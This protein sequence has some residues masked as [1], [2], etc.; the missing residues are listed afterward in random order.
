M[1]FANAHYFWFL[2]MLFIFCV[3]LVVLSF[4]IKK[5]FLK[6][7]GRKNNFSINNINP[8]LYNIRI[9]IFILGL[10]FIFISLLDPR[11]GSKSIAGNLEGID[12]VLTFDISR[13]MLTK[14][15]FPDRLSE[16]KRIGNKIL[17]KLIGNR[18]GLTAF[19]GFA[20]NIIPLTT[21]L[22]AARTFIDELNT[23]MIDIQGTNLEDA[24]RKAIELF[25]ENI[26][27]H[28]VIVIIT[29]GE[30]YEFNPMKSVKI[31][32]EKGIIIFTV[33]IGT[34]E[35][36]KIPIFDNK[37]NIIDYLKKDGKVV[38]SKLNEKMLREIAEETKGMYFHAKD[39]EKLISRIDEIKKTKYG[40]SKYEFLELQYQYFLFIALLLFLIY[41]FLPFNKINIDFIKRVLI[42][43]TTLMLTTNNAF[44]SL[45]TKGV[46]EYKKENYEEALNL[47]QKA[48]IKDNKNS[49]L[50]YNIGNTYYKLNNLENAEKYY[51][52][53]LNSTDKKLINKANYNL[54]NLYLEKGNLIEAIEKYK[55]VLLNEKE[56]SELYKK[57]LL[58]LLYAK[59]QINN[60]NSN[61]QNQQSSENEKSKKEKQKNSSSSQSS[62]SSSE[63]QKEDNQMQ[64]NIDAENLLNLLKEEEKKHM[65]KKEKRKTIGIYPK[66]EW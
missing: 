43:L 65:S 51:K 41:I 10:F 12:I 27:T 25:D 32:K 58:N 8:F 18:V 63:N 22:E 55:E 57:A 33:G 24:I 66:N 35:G 17:T 61:Q 36:E 62:S 59:Q 60:T 42:I 46:K 1:I 3:L 48:L 23:E 9:F 29:D 30:D 7:I 50:S 44:S 11:W 16:A 4:I 2:L 26:L 47:F 39:I 38:F 37:G 15:V 5:N 20:F 14:D 45:K 31:A 13:S 6:V 52:K 40:I 21:D 54:G 19:A 28:K 64:Q 49:R 56:G 34:A 53:S